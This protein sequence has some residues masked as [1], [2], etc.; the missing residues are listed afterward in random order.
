MLQFTSINWPSFA[1]NWQA[2]FL[3]SADERN[4]FSMT[5]VPEAKIDRGPTACEEDVLLAE[6]PCLV[7]PFNAYSM[8][9][10][11]NQSIFWINGIQ[12]IQLV[13][14]FRPVKSFHRVQGSM[15][16]VDIFFCIFEIIIF[17]STARSAKELKL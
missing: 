8:W 9:G 4:Y 5:N 13:S 11:L 7:I 14:S 10:P 2:A 16:S 17:S 6:L 3:E 15:F 1:S 12:I